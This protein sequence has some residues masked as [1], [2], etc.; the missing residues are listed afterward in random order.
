MT[1]SQKLGQIG[2]EF[3]SPLHHVFLLLGIRRGVQYE[4]SGEVR[5]VV[6]HEHVFAA[7]ILQHQQL[8][9]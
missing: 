6:P 2:T 7:H 9:L 4:A 8:V 1:N 5:L 3:Y